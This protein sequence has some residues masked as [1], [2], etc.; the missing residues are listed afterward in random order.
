MPRAHTLE[1]GMQRQ[2]PTREGLGRGRAVLSGLQLLLVESH[3]LPMS[4]GKA[5]GGRGESGQPLPLLP[6]AHGTEPGTD[7]YVSPSSWLSAGQTGRTDQE[8][9]ETKVPL[10]PCVLTAVPGAEDPGVNQIEETHTSRS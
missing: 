3:L 1:G 2:G 5:C 10:S 6:P 9:L 4:E 7:T 8:H